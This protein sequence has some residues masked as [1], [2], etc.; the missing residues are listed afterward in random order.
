M[1][2]GELY[3]L[4]IDCK[5]DRQYTHS[6]TTTMWWPLSSR[7]FRLGAWSTEVA[8]D[9]IVP[10]AFDAAQVL[11]SK[12]AFCAFRHHVCDKSFYEGT[13]APTRVALFDAFKARYKASTSL[14]SCREDS[15]AR[16]RWEVPSS[17]EWV[18]VKGR[19]Q[20][21][22]GGSKFGSSSV[23]SFK[24]FKFVIAIENSFALG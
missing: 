1:R 5:F 17:K 10:P 9:L 14:G 15:A 12:S 4:V 11:R 23:L 21:P 3:D 8:T 18:R 2:S 22:P 7:Y 13:G 16:D 24:P 19:A 20:A 6:H